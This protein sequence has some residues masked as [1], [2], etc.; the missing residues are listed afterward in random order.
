MVIAGDKEVQEGTV[1][2]RLKSGKEIKGITLEDF[3][4]NIVK[5]VQGREIVGP[6][7]NV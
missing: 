3:V 6:W 1:S 5:E 4:K 7:A 2:V